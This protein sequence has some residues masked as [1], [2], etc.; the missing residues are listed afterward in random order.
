MT[1]V[2]KWKH[3]QK[4]TFSGNYSLRN[5][6]QEPRKRKKKLHTTRNF[7]QQRKK[8]IKNLLAVG[9]NKKRS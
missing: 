2:D 6:S 1:V 5:L 3:Q 4:K 7:T 8:N 9:K